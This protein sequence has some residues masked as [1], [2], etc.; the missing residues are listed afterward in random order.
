MLL[1]PREKQILDADQREKIN[2]IFILS[3]LYKISFLMD[4]KLCFFFFFFNN[5]FGNGDPGKNI[6]RSGLCKIMPIRNSEQRCTLYSIFTL[7]SNYMY[8]T[9]HYA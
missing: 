1:I 6:G 7:Y 9:V 8:D 3:H 4:L 2:F 5:K